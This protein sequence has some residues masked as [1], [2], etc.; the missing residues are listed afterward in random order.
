LE[1]AYIK[2][3]DKFPLSDFL[4]TD[5]LKY[6]DPANSSYTKE[7]MQVV[8]SFAITYY[9]RVDYPS[10]QDFESSCFDWTIKQEFDFSNRNI[11]K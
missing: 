1:V 3:Q 5:D 6:F 10:V 7:F 8:S 11:I 2:P 4:T 9:V